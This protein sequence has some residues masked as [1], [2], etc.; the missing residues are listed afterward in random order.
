MAAKYFTFMSLSQSLFYFGAVTGRH[1]CFCQLKNGIECRYGITDINH[2]KPSE[3]VVENSH[4]GTGA[5]H[6]FT[7]LA[8]GGWLSANPS[9]LTPRSSACRWVGSF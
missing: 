1:S 6:P 2:G 9:L 8:D 7:A 5:F 4:S 3:C